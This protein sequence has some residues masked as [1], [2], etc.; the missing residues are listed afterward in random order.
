MTDDLKEQYKALLG[1]FEMVSALYLDGDSIYQV[2]LTSTVGQDESIK[3][4]VSDY[5]FKDPFSVECSDA[6]LEAV[7]GQM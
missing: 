5:G 3:K 7:G 1:D 6:I 2:F 4:I